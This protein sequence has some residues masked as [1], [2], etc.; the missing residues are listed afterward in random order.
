MRR[1]IKYQRGEGRKKRYMKYQRGDGLRSLLTS[2]RTL[3]LRRL[4]RRRRVQRGRGF[5]DK[6]KN[7]VKT[8]VS[9]PI[10]KKVAKDVVIPLAIGAIHKKMYTLKLGFR[11]I[12]EHSDSLNVV[13]YEVDPHLKEM[14]FGERGND[15]VSVNMKLDNIEMSYLSDS[16]RIH[17]TRYITCDK[18]NDEMKNTKTGNNFSTKTDIVMNKEVLCHVLMNFVSL[19]YGNELDLSQ[20]SYNIPVEFFMGKN[21]L[22]KN[23]KFFFEI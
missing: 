17:Y 12:S 2:T 3:G 4:C 19:S 11:G 10:V 14:Y 23:F 16:F 5:W 21:V 1:Y 18:S 20:D 6:V 15:V 22:D 8:V 13:S 7:G 9:H